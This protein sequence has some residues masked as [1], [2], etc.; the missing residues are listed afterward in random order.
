MSKYAV[1]ESYAYKDVTFDGSDLTPPDPDADGD[2]VFSGN[3]ICLLELRDALPLAGVGSIEAAKLPPSDG[4]NVPSRCK[5]AGWGA[6]HA[7]GPITG[8]LTVSLQSICNLT[9]PKSEI[10]GGRLLGAE[11]QR[12]SPVRGLSRRARAAEGGRPGS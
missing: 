8:N 1:H 12:L 11:P 6:T 2:R 3:D 9:T 10:E 7:G 4:V 5:V